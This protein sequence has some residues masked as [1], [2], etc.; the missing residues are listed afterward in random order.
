VV[1]LP[2]LLVVHPSVP[3]RSLAELIALAKQKPDQLTYGSAGT[4]TNPHLS[5]ELF[6]TMAGVEIRHIPYKG[7]GP[8]L[9]DLVAGQVSTLIAGM[10]TTKPQVEAGTLRGLAVTSLR[11]VDSLPAIPT[12]AEAGV[13]NYEAL[14]WYGLL[15][16]AGT[17]APIIA[18][19]HAE[20]AKAVRTPDMKERLAAD[21]ADPVGNTPEEF[22]AHIKGEMAK[23]AA[24]ARAAKIEPQ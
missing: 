3:V 20:T 5:M 16:P 18:R 15:A 23:W 19:L 6:K 21:G 22:A 12:V 4:G 13:P 14:Q 10:L 1:S 2:S 9:N 7:V 8:A 24:V 17:P 11:R